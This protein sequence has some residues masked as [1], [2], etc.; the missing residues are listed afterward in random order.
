MGLTSILG[1][2][3][4]SSS[5]MVGALTRLRTCVLSPLT[6]CFSRLLRRRGFPL[7]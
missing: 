3:I 6:S 2:R 5:S 1:G 4:S 7:L